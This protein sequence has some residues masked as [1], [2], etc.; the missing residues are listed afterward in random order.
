MARALAACLLLT[1]A[2]GKPWNKAFQEQLERAWKEPA[3][4]FPCLAPECRKPE[5][6]F[7]RL[8]DAEPGI[9][10]MDH[11]GYCGSWSI[12]RA[13]MVKG[14]WISQQQ[15]RNHTVPGG[16]HD[17]EILETNID[18]ALKNLKLKSEGFDYKHLPTPQADAYRRWIKSKLVAGHAVVWMI[19]LAGGHFPVY[20][21]LPYGFYSHIEPVVGIMSDHNLTDDKWYD[22]DVVVHYT[23]ADSHTYYRT[24]KSLPDDL[25]MHGNC[26]ALHSIR[27]SGYPC[28]YTKYGFGWSV[29]GF[30]DQ[31]MPSLPLPLSLNVVP[32]DREPDVR[33]GDSPIPLQGKVHVRGLRKGQKYIIY[34]WDTVAAAFDYSHPHFTHTFTASD[35][36]YS[37]DDPQT[38]QSD[39]TTYYRCLEDTGDVLVV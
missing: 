22:D 30:L 12:Q 28:I 3:R 39:G 27:Y 13:A 14:A 1:L 32:A 25:D 34:R 37:Y 35:V 38:F 20:P 31:N 17:N 15:V 16:G 23:D 36:T 8:F 2:E 5:K 9:Q 7:E 21:S 11:G 10:W 6:K 19:M 26:N 33:L 18:L 29:E 4:N 24:M